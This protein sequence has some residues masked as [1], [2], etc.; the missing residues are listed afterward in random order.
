MKL[1]TASVYSF[2]ETKEIASFVSSRSCQ[3]IIQHELDKYMKTK[4]LENIKYGC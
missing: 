2:V 3:I 4:C 1:C